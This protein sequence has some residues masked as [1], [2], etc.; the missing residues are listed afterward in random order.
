[1]ARTTFISLFFILISI[2]LFG[3]AF[4]EEA[5]TGPYATEREYLDQRYDRTISIEP[6][7]VVGLVRAVELEVSDQVDD[8]C[9]TNASAVSARIRAQLENAKIA[10]YTEPLAIPTPFSP[11][12]IVT[13]LGFKVANGPCVASASMSVEYA[14]KT[15]LG[16][17]AFT[18]NIFRVGGT[19]VIWRNSTLL[20]RGGNVNETVLSEVQEWVDTLTADVALAKRNANV[21]KLLAVWSA[22]PPQTEREFQAEMQKML[23]DMEK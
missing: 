1:M 11:K 15:Y 19:Q 21:Q 14:N 13:V 9:F 4:A 22:D 20:S 5:P 6:Q 10:V 3:S 23:S 12:L 16:S 7:Y 2:Q 8:K 18:G 17:L